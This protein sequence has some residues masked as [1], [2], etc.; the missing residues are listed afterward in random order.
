M[1]PLLLATCALLLASCTSKSNK[2]PVRLGTGMQT[3]QIP[4]ALAQSLG[5]FSDE[6]LAVSIETLSTNGKTAQALVGG[7]VDVAA[8]AY[9][10][11]IHLAAEGLSLRSFFFSV[12]RNSTV[13]VTTSAKIRRAE[14]LK[15]V[16]IGIPSTGAAVLP[17]LNYYLLQHGVQPSEA[18]TIP[19]GIAASAVAAIE[20]GRVD[21]AAVAGGDHLRLQRR[22]PA[23]RI[24]VDGSTPEGLRE[25]FASDAYVTG[26]LSARREWLDQNPDTARRLARALARTLQWIATH[27]PEEIREKLPASFRSDDPALD[28]EIIRWGLDGYTPDGRMPAGA[29]EAMKRFLDTVYDN[30]RNAKIDLNATWTNDFLPIP[31]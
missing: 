21:A 30:V 11:I 24:L 12:R 9:S 29:P 28:L 5:F 6:G 19:I 23:L 31:Q 25:L 3:Q 26:A 22:I 4:F 16:K 18:A 20:A 14:D 27:K 2:I 13:I 7:S 15:G 1:K 8:I 17:F 10:Q